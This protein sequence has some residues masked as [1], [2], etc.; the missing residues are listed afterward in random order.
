MTTRNQ[1]NRKMRS[2]A[3][4]LQMFDLL[5]NGSKLESQNYRYILKPHHVVQGFVK[6]FD[7]KSKEIIVTYSSRIML[8]RDL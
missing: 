1:M 8:S 7:S 6:Y 4:L 3:R 5:E 2:V